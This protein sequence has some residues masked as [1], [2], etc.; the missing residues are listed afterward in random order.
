MWK[1]VNQVN[2]DFVTFSWAGLKG[3]SKAKQYRMQRIQHRLMC[4]VQ[5]L[6]MN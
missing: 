6:N 2:I 5:S 4:G 3:T 1:L